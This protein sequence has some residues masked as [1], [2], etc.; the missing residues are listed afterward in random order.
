[1]TRHDDFLPVTMAEA[2]ETAW[3]HLMFLKFRLCKCFFF[4]LNFVF[5]L[6]VHLLGPVFSSNDRLNVYIINY[7]LKGASVRLGPSSHIMMLVV[8]LYISYVS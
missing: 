2:V 5:L 3:Q 8:F 1:M 7:G 6:F 4:S